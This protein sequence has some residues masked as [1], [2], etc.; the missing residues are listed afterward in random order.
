MV[1]DVITNS[2]NQPPIFPNF[3][4]VLLLFHLKKHER[5]H[6]SILVSCG[7]SYVYLYTYISN[8]EKYIPDFTGSGSCQG[9]WK[10]E[11][12]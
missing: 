9:V 10:S 5:T 6:N 4:D 1:S 12:E 11:K 2:E 3:P 7:F 8:L